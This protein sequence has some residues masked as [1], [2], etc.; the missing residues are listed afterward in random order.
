MRSEEYTR[1]NLV[2][3]MAS[4]ET[5]QAFGLPMLGA[6]R[7][8]SPVTVIKS[9]VPVFIRILA[10]LFFGLV[11]CNVAKSEVR[12]CPDLIST[13]TEYRS[14][15]GGWQ[16]LTP[17]TAR[18]ISLA[19]RVTDTPTPH[20]GLI[21]PANPT[22][23]NVLGTFNFWAYRV[24]SIDGNNDPGTC[25]NAA[26]SGSFST[27]PNSFICA[28]FPGENGSKLWLKVLLGNDSLIQQAW[29]Y[30]NN[31]IWLSSQ[32]ITFNPPSTGVVGDVLTLS[33]NGGGSTSPVTFS[34]VSGPCS[35][36][37]STLTL[38]GAGNCVVRASQIGD[39]NFLA[40]PDVDR[41]IAVTQINGIPTLSEWGKLLLVL[42]M[43]LIGWTRV[44]AARR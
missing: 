16:I 23:I 21:G 38:T 2:C 41:T 4:G 39:S 29:S 12:A 42:L 7:K 5:S 20:F 30:T 32:A 36:A 27:S 14:G 17:A 9:R 13:S 18:F 6:I 1:Q 10:T 22:V 8:A 15:C 11:L 44:R 24:G 3:T 25:E 26:Y 35:L 31:P 33:A 19:I 37:N 34:V 43:L 40:A 28:E